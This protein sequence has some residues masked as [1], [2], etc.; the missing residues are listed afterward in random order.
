MS[1]T[2]LRLSRVY[3]EIGEEDGL[4]DVVGGENHVFRSEKVVHGNDVGSRKRRR[5]FGGDGELILI[6]LELSVRIES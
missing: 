4:A 1:V 6:L 2:N 3:G 5:R